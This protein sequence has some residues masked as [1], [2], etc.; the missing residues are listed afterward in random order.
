VA[1]LLQATSSGRDPSYVRQV[2]GSAGAPDVRLLVFDP[3][4]EEARRP[5]LVYIHGGGMVMGHAAQSN[6]TLWRLADELGAVVVSVD[7]RLAPE[8]AF[9]GPLE[10]CHAGLLALVAAADEL[11]VDTSRIVVMGE[12]A[13]GGLA[14]SLALLARDYGGPPIRGQVLIYPMLDHRTGGPDDIYCNPATGRWIWTRENN[15]HGWLAL[16]GPRPLDHLHTGHFSPSR[17]TRLDGLPASYIEVGALDLFHD[18]C[19]DYARRLAAAAV[20]VELHVRPGAPHGF[21]LMRTAQVSIAA[22]AQRL[23][24]L[25][26]LL[27]AQPFAPDAAAQ[28]R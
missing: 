13:G 18:E 3:P 7:Y 15:Q 2:R 8:T 17:A 22:E 16:Q 14:A 25:R 23:G 11:R 1:Q 6:A 26:G 21:D 9:P 19:L 28:A 4:S 12:S 27:A 10:D 20:P 24:A 5:A